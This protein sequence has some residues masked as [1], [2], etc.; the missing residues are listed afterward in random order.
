MHELVCVKCGR[1]EFFSFDLALD[2]FVCR[3]CSEEHKRGLVVDEA[4]RWDE[5]G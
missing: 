1:V 4:L 2:R 5:D 3:A